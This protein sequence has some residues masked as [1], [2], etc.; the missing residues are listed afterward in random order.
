MPS[1]AQVAVAQRRPG[2]RRRPGTSAGVGGTE[3]TSDRAAERS[4]SASTTPRAL[5]VM[6]L[7]VLRPERFGRLLHVDPAH[8]GE[9]AHDDPGRARD[10]GHVA[11]LQA[12][13]RP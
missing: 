12:R 11:Q 1:A 9:A 5:S 8:D 13:A 10:D 7:A 4:L 2:R 3:R 6:A